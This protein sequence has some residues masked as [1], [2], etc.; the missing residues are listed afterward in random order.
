M[1]PPIANPIENIVDSWQLSE[2]A[3]EVK[4]NV[5]REILKITRRPNIISFAG[6]LPAP[7]LF[8]LEG[9]RDACNRVI[10][11]FGPQSLQYTLS[12]GIPELRQWL[13][14]RISRKGFP[15]S[16]DEVLITGGSQQGLDLIG[17]VFL[18]KGAM[19]LTET[20]TYL[21]ALQA[22]NL[23]QAQ[24]VAVDMDEDGMVVEQ[25]E[26]KIKRYN[27][28]FLYVVPNF[29]NP[30]GITLSYERRVM[31]VEL[32]RKYN[33]PIIDD[34]PYGELRFEGKDVP[35]LKTIGGE[36]VI[37]LGTFSKIISPGLRIGWVAA[38][39]SICNA[40]ERMKQGSDLHTNTFAQYVIY[41]FVKT[42]ALDTHIEKI[43]E[44]YAERRAVMIEAMQEYFPEGVK[45]TRPQGGLF[46]WIELPGQLSAEDLLEEAVENG[47]AFVPGS[48][49]FAQGGGHNT[50]RLNF[51]NAT[52]D[53]IRE[54]IKR[55]GN[56]F[57]KH[58]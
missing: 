34:N 15:V 4:A 37:Q 43:K 13:A 18:D 11:N 32:A 20:P 10:D 41:E 22:F 6:G 25:V 12:F 24:Y 3:Y 33:V 45:F 46:L 9:I 8:P 39:Q 27:P 35:S 55:L 44:A 38:T 7:E 57:K 58:I 51:S 14:E 21:G 1:N 40:F 28:R 29:Q 42:G 48:P 36:Y 23:Y 31:L 16:E 52:P 49:F 53:K 50:M 19:V 2:R 56:V 30:S 17:K 26:A 47:V 5:I 54:G